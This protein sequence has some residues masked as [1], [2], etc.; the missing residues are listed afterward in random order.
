MSLFLF[1]TS[2]TSRARRVQ[3]RSVASSCISLSMSVFQTPSHAGQKRKPDSTESNQGS[4]KRRSLGADVGSSSLDSGR[5]DVHITDRAYGEQYWMVQWY[6][7]L[8]CLPHCKFL[9]MSRRRAPQ[10]KKHKTW[11]G[12]GILALNGLKG[13]LY[14]LEGKMWASI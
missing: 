13:V 2:R 9:R 11:D 6:G 14:D 4:N 7:F 3:A 8:Q 5:R 1:V 10:Y 12:D